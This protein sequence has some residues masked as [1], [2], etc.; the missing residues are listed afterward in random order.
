MRLFRAHSNAIC[1]VADSQMS[2]ITFLESRFCVVLLIS[3]RGTAAF[4]NYF[5]LV[6]IYHL[7]HPPTRI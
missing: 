1:Y 3:V 6:T 5:L 7:N 4:Q 2:T